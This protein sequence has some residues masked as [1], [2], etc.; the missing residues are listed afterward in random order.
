MQF[1]H[2]GLATL[3]GW[4]G[5]TRQAYYEHKKKEAATLLEEELVIKQVKEIRKNHPSMGARKLY[6]KLQPFIQAH[7]IKLGRDGLFDL[8]AAYHL[9]IRKRKRKIQTT[10]SL[11]RFKKYPNQIKDFTPKEPNE[12]W[13]SDIT[14]WQIREKYCYISLITDAYS[15]KIVGYQ[16]GESLE[17]IESIQA[18]RMALSALDGS[19]S[20]AR[21]IHHSDRGIQYCSNGYV[22]LLEEYKMEISMTQNGDPLENAIAERV[23]GIIKE[24]YL[25]HHQVSSIQE[26]REILQQVIQLYNH[27]RPHMNCVQKQGFIK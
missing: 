4:F 1:Q 3:C 8:L 2:K 27:D 20:H 16:V 21:L 17:A 11:H 5:I 15:H 12:L 26:A 6:L 22:K 9:L 14:Y 13:V 18:L 25:V 23:N 24:E 10:Q 7:K 19:E